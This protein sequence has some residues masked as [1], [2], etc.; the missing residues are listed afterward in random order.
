MPYIALT[1]LFIG[2]IYRSM[3]WLRFRQKSQFENLNNSSNTP[4]KMA[5]FI[6]GM[7]LEIFFLRKVYRGSFK[8]WLISWP[9]HMAILGMFVGHLRLFTELTPLWAIFNMTEPEIEAFST[10][11]GTIVGT[12]FVVGLALLLVRRIVIKEVRAIST[13]D[14]YLTLIIILSAGLFGMGMRL[15]PE[16]H[17]ILTEFREYFINALFLNPTPIPPYNF[18]FALHAFLNYITLIWLP[19]S[20]LIH[21]FTVPVTEAIRDVLK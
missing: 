5:N 16:G 11:S 6:K 7:I 14:D 3:N 8:L 18:Y 19:F 2:L 17:I 15:L 21:I 20:K 4:T 10:L 12:I 13:Y 1:T 9:M